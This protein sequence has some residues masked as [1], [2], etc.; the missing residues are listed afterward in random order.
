[1]TVARTVAA[2]VVASAVLAGGLPAVANAAPGELSGPYK[3]TY[4]RGT[5]ADWV[6][7]AC[8]PGC[9]SASSAND[10]RRVVDGWE[11]RLNGNTWSF[12]GVRTIRCSPTQDI[13]AQ[14]DY[15]FDAGSLAGTATAT[16]TTVTC[17]TAPL[18]QAVSIPFQLA[19]V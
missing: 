16:L 3:V 6:F 12:A 10:K 14:V 11:F 13:P 5:P 2:G 19:K 8:G 4:S 17:G 15:S 1:M 18:G 9:A 7:T